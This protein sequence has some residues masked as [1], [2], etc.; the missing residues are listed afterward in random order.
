VVIPQPT[1]FHL[2]QSIAGVIEGHAPWLRPEMIVADAR[3]RGCSGTTIA[4]GLRDLD[5]MI[6]IV[7]VAA[8]GEA[9]PI[10][11]DTTLRIVDAG[12]AVSTVAE[13][14]GGIRPAHVRPPPV[15]SARCTAAPA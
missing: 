4:A 2:I 6:P 3:L 13:L 8:P 9:L 11:S 5:I 1:G 7:L 14:A 12:A 15:P 10:S